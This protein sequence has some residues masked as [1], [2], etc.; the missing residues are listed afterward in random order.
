MTIFGKIFI[1]VLLLAIVVEVWVLNQWIQAVR[2]N[3]DLSYKLQVCE[4]LQKK[5]GRK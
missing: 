5:G 2:A 3:E 1:F 4:M